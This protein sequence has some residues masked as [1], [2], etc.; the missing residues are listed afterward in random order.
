M[1]G[2]PKRL[3][4]PEQGR[5]HHWCKYTYESTLPNHEEKP[6]LHTTVLWERDRRHRHV[7]PLIR[8]RWG[9]MGS[10]PERQNPSWR[11]PS[12]TQPHVTKSRSD[13]YQRVIHKSNEY[14][15]ERGAP[16]N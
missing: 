2:Y 11:L 15:P 5:R 4:I 8:G 1:S 9:V 16:M 12:Y 3:G 13:F 7:I 14:I 6:R 10:I